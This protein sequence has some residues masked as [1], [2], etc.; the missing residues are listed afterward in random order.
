MPA[1]SDRAKHVVLIVL[2]VAVLGATVFTIYRIFFWKETSKE[3][4]S[5]SEKAKQSGSLQRS[6]DAIADG[7]SDDAPVGTLPY[8]EGVPLALPE[9]LSTSSPRAETS[10]IVSTPSTFFSSSPSSQKNTY[11]FYNAQDG[12]FYRIDENGDVVPLSDQAFYGVKEVSWGNADDRAILEFPDG[13]N[14]LFSFKDSRQIT[15]PKH[16]EDFEFSQDD[17]K[18]VAKSVGNN[19]SNRFLVVANP[20]GSDAEAVQELGDNADKVHTTW[21]PNQQVVAYSF[22]G[23][24]IGADREQVILVGK[25]QENLPGLITEGRGFSPNWSPNGGSLAYS[26]YTSSNGYLPELW[27]TSGNGD[28]INKNRRRVEL[29]TWV[30]KCTWRNE[31]TMYC[32]VPEY[33]EPGAALQPTVAQR[34]NDRLFRIDVTSG[35]K[36]NLGF[37]GGVS[38]ITNLRVNTEGTVATFV[39]GANGRVLRHTLSP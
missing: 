9:D 18:I 10:V 11:R 35:R 33:L 21:S 7:T 2:L 1:L 39:D 4:V 30:E 32:A 28:T 25:N 3:S 16:W 31:T 5:D 13:S 22:T 12:K 8:Q 20:D 19:E 6:G 24:P 23:D 15:L 37:V 29:N 36:T 27:I 14:I 17:G 26:V 34:G 38:D